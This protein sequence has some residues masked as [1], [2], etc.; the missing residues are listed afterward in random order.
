[1]GIWFL[2]AISIFI[3]E[4]F[5]LRHMQK[6]SFKLW[7]T[8]KYKTKGTPLS[9]TDTDEKVFAVFISLAIAAFWPLTI[10]IFILIAIVAFGVV[11]CLKIIGD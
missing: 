2:V 11:G 8:E 9:F 4:L 6:P 1:M 7:Y 5:F 3:A 10:P